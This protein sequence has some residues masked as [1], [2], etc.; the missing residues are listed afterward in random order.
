M[1]ILEFVF[2]SFWHWL[3]SL[4]L[5]TVVFRALAS[6]TPVRVTPKLSLDKKEF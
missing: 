5:L 1:E 6:W 4:I 2:Q 3:G